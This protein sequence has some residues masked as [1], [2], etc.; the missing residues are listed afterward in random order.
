[1]TLEGQEENYNVFRWYR[2][3]WGRYTQADPIG[4]GASL[5]IYAYVDGNPVNY[6]D[7]TGLVKVDSSCTNFDD[8][9]C[10][11]AIDKAAKDFNDFWKPGWGQRKPKCRQKLIDMGK[12]V[13]APP[14]F[15]PITCMSKLTENMTVKCSKIDAGAFGGPPLNIPQFTNPNDIWIQPNACLNKTRPGFLLDTI[16]HEAL[17]NCGAPF[18][19]G[20]FSGQAMAYDITS[21]CLGE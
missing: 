10:G 2:A 5:N 7:P 13:S 6:S 14:P 8:C 21:V 17:H 9:G 15:T 19:A 1:M 18:D 11:N 3:G 12:I 20:G 4:L 16:F